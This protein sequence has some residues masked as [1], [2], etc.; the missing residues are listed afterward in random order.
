MLRMTVR[1]KTLL[2]IAITC[3][4]LVVALYATSRRFLLGGFVKLEQTSAKENVQ[5][6]LNAYDQDIA[7]MD[8]FT[9]DR[10]SIDETYDG[11]TAQTPELL[12]WLIGR[13]SSGTAQTQR[14]NFVLLIDP[15]G[16]LLAA[17]GY[18]PVLKKVMEIPESLLAHISTNDALLRTTAETGKVNGVLLLPE[19]P[20]LVVCRPVI[21]PNST[22]PL[23]GYMLSARFLESAGDLKMLER[24]TNF[25]LSIQQLDDQKLPEDFSL[26]A[27]HLSQAGDIFTQPIDNSVL[28]GYTLLDDIYGKPALIL[29]A[30]LPRRIYGQGRVS[31]LY[32]A[33]SLLIAGLVFATAVILLLEKSVISRLS[34]LSTSVASITGS[35]D[36]SSRVHCPGSDELSHL[37]DAIN[38]MLESLQLSQTQRMQ[39]EERYGAFMKNIPA[40]ALIKD[41]EGRVLYINER[42]SRIYKINL[43]EVRGK[44]ASNWIPA[45]VASEIRQHDQEV[46]SAKHALQFEEV[47]PTPDGVPHHWLAFRFPIV[48]PGGE[49]LL[50]MVAV[51]ISRRKKVEAELLDAKE[52]AEAANRAKSEFLANMSHEIRTPLNGVVGMTDLA[53]ATDLTAEQQEYLE[54]VK[55]SADSLLTVIN[56]ILDFS[57]IEAGKIDFE[58]IDFD[59]RETMEMTMKTLAFRAGEKRLELI[60]DIAPNV[61]DGIQGDSTRLRQVVVNLVGNAIKFTEAGEVALN[62]GVTHGEGGER[63]L[64]FTVSDTG[65]GIPLDKQ[66][67]IFD[68]FSQADTS[69]TRKF[70]GTGLGLSISVRLVQM[71]GG[72]M[73]VESKPGVETEFH[74]TI[75]LLPALNP[76]SARAGENSKF[77]RGV[78]ALIVD[79]NSTNRRILELMLKRWEMVPTAVQSGAEAIAELLSS[80]AADEPYGLILSDV[81]M[82]GMDGF[83][84][85]ERVRQEPKLSSAKIVMLTSAG[86]RGDAARCRELGISAYAMKPVRRSE[87]LDVISRLLDGREQDPAAPLITRYS[88]ANERTAARSL[89]VLIAEDNLVNQK[90]VARLLEKRGHTVRI[91]CNGREALECLVQAPYDLVLMDVQMPDMDGFEA[92]GEL[93]RREKLTGLHTPIIALTAHAMKGDRERC[94]EAGMDGYLSKPIRAAELD[95]WLAK[96]GAPEPIGAGRPQHEKL[97]S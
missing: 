72:H 97:I 46:L 19:G 81:L 93:R 28:G 65:I 29:K 80:P 37:G 17:R 41:A 56:D 21:R 78:K 75:P 5:R 47:V 68:P 53:L 14:L 3:L 23:H 24:T 50:G 88:I 69:T 20:L 25:K 96:F 38:R 34:A 92:T 57:K 58:T 31:Q 91:A 35:G 43:D 74:F 48:E 2:I 66:K 33:V 22:D 89:R 54:T 62:I 71:M 30:E 18:D 49:L 11:M 73:W 86:Q 6:V 1:R 55:L 15:A 61:P 26:A 63:L 82:P 12:H 84:F 40:I 83:A 36:A 87:L 51:D 90:L 39:T 85:A 32:F 64:H 52:M 76:I 70:G 77:L 4:V 59:L 8:R 9:Y 42:M 60:C 10:A 67:S 95:E 27:G 45:E 16:R 94:H 44:A 7:A 13:D 79:D